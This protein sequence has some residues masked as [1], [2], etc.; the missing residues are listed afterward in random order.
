MS[1]FR[2]AEVTRPAVC[3][4]CRSKF[5]GT[6]AKVISLRTL[7]RCR[8]CEATWTL[9]PLKPEPRPSR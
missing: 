5:V 1:E 8:A 4:F 2:Q 7:W 9:A 6:L 3:P